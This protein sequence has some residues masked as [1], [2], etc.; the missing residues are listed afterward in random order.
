[1]IMNMN[2]YILNRI[3]NYFR[4]Q[5][6][7]KHQELF[8]NDSY[9]YYQTDLNFFNEVLD[10]IEVREGSLKDKSFIDLGSGIGNICAVAAKRW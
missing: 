9:Q 8:G 2:E 6:V 5:V 3:N 7:D 1:M 4:L 10:I